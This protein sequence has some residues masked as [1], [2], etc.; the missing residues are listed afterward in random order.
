[1]FNG[2][3]LS[4]ISECYFGNHGIAE[5]YLGM[6]KIWPKGNHDYSIDYLTFE[7]TKN[8]STLDFRC[9]TN[10]LFPL[11]IYISTDNG[12]TWTQKTSTN[13]GYGNG[14]IL[15]TLNIGDKLLVKG[16]NS[17]YYSGGKSN[18]FQTTE[19]GFNVYGNIMSLV[20]GDNFIGQT[21]FPSNTNSNFYSLFGG[22]CNFIESIDNLILPATTLTDS[23]YKY[24]FLGCAGLTTLPSGLLPATSLADD[25]YHAMFLDCNGLTTL[26]SGLLPATSLAQYCYESMFMDCNGLISVSSDLLSSATFLEDYCYYNMFNGCTSL[27]TAP[28]L[29]ATSLT[30]SCYYKMFLGCTN[31]NYIKCLARNISADN[32][33]T[34]W[35]SGVSATGTFVKNSSAT[36]WTTGT[37]GIPT[38]WRIIT[39]Q[40]Y[41]LKYLTFE[42]L[43]DNTTFSFSVNN[44]QYSLDDGS[45]WTVLTAGSSTP[46]LNTGERILWK[47][48]GLT[49]DWNDGIGH[50]SSTGNYKA[51]GNIMSILFGDNF[52]N[53]TTLNYNAPVFLNLF[54][55]NYNLKDITNLKLPATTLSA[56]CYRYMFNNCGG[57]TSIPSGFLPSTTLANYCYCGMFNGCSGITSIPSDLLAATTLLEGCYQNMFN[58]CSGITS[59]MELTAA[60]LMAYCYEGM[61][62]NCSSLNYIKCLATGGFDTTNCLSNW[63]Y[64]VSASGTFDRD[65]NTVW[66]I[67]DSGIPTGWTINP[68]M[69]HDYSLDYLTFEALE[70]TTFS[71]S[72]NDL[73]YSLD[74]GSTWTTLT[75]DTS[76]PQLSTG[77]KILWKQTNPT[78]SSNGIGTFSAT[79]NFKAY[80]NI[81]S[82][83]YGDNFI[84]KKNLS[85]KNYVFKNLFNSNTKLINAENLI[86][87]ATAL[88]QSCYYQ[89][90][91]NCTSLTTA[92]ELPATTLANSCYESMFQGCTSLTSIQSKLP[93][94]TLANYCYQ[95]M[96]N[97][98]TSLTTVPSDF[99]PATKLVQQCYAGMFQGCTSLTT[100]PELPATTSA[101][102]CYYMMFSGCSLLNYIKCLLS[103]DPGYNANNWVNRVSASGTFVK[104]SSTTWSTG[105]SGIPTGWTVQNA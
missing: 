54:E 1:M 40:D 62:Y 51:Y 28:E 92:P 27:T 19:G 55:W 69:E 79:G 37:S 16:N 2:F 30:D 87:P 21:N 6:T 101:T 86:L 4:Y 70:P 32:C 96:F 93:S 8:N 7:A 95:Y 98:C 10:N 104:N 89:M 105:N 90:F 75:A 76:T 50:F 43:A 39:P 23:C 22:N 47:Q 15:A 14:T 77:D 68:P 102:Y 53:Q 45:T 84:N 33:L 42:A 60:T 58:G 3:D 59:A 13:D 88:A 67:G 25:C 57:L 24:M 81:M 48:T 66:N 65:S 31:L 52:S 29:P 97:S 63:V 94:T 26:P 5:I 49:P 83:L 12:S 64:N 100:A 103:T 80:G 17:V 82:L 91:K 34:D 11:D 72:T 20:Y 36:A 35:V 9:D 56:H 73:Q 44:I 74:G 46:S 85:S 61:F 18:C 41:S 99:L 38:G 78:I 71:F